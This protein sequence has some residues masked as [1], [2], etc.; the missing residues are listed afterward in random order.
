M[1]W[2]NPTMWAQLF[3]EN[4]DHLRFELDT[5]IANLTEYRDAIAD[6]DEARLT[7]LLDDGRRRKEAVDGK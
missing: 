3:L 1:A 5:I 6:H 2:L 7:Q 4:G